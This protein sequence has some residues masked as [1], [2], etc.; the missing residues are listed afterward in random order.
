M[1]DLDLQG[2]APYIGGQR[3]P[4]VLF[5]PSGAVVA[6][7]GGLNNG[8]KAYLVNVAPVGG[9]GRTLLRV[10]N[11]NGAHEVVTVLWADPAT[12]VVQTDSTTTPGSF[13]GSDL[14]AFTMDAT[15]GAQN[16]LP[17]AL[18]YVVAVLN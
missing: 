3:S 14:H 1:V 8:D 9:T 10:D 4:S 12:L 16:P 2:T 7:W 18:H 6:W 13:Q 11:T 17:A 15:T 5:A